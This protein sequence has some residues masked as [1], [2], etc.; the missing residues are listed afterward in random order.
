MSSLP[1]NVLTLPVEC[2]FRSSACTKNTHTHAHARACAR[3]PL[4]KSKQEHC[5]IHASLVRKS[6][7]C[8]LSPPP[9]VLA[10][11]SRPEKILLSLITHL[12]PSTHTHTP[13]TACSYGYLGPSDTRWGEA[14]CRLQTW[15]ERE[16]LWAF[17]FFFI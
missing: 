10:L 6:L 2:R 5:Q 1:K 16:P 4:G 14:T 12:P 9:P 13:D 3:A 11:H 8:P 7:C 17:I 15:D